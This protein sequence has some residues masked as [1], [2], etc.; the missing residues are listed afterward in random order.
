MKMTIIM[1]YRP[2][3]GGMNSVYGDLIQQE[4]GDWHNSNGDCMNGRDNLINIPRR[5]IEFLRKNSRFKHD[6]VVAIDS[7]MKP[8][9][10]WL[11]EYDNVRIFQSKYVCPEPSHHAW[12]RLVATQRDA[13]LSLPDDEIVCYG[14]IADLVCSKNWDL[15]IDE[16]YKEYG[17]DKTYVPMFVEARS[18]RGAMSA[19]IGEAAKSEVVE[20]GQVTHEKIWTKWRELCMH[21]LTIP[22]QT[23]HDYMTEEY[24][25]EWIKIAVSVPIGLN[26][27]ILEKCGTRRYGYWLP[28]ISKNNRLKQALAGLKIGPGWDLVFEAHLGIKAVIAKSFVLHTHFNAVWDNQEVHHV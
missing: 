26:G 22:P 8:H 9:E 27:V 28:L 23:D 24:F 3:R 6:I 16:A 21:A 4:N 2:C 14:Y 10:S 25:D 7:D 18:P 1:P 11:K 5:A 17:D 13:M 15:Y 12:F 20:L 19:V